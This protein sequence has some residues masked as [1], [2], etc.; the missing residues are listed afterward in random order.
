[1]KIRRSAAIAGL[2]G[3]GLA[4]GIVLVG[5]GAAYAAA[6]SY[7][8]D[9]QSFGTLSFFDSSGNPVTSG[10]ITN[11]PLAA[12]VV[13]SNPG[14]TGDTS[15]LLNL[16]QPNPNS[17][18]SGWNQDNLTGSSA[19]PLPAAG[20]PANIVALSQTHPVSKGTSS[21]FTVANFIS[22]FPNTGPTGTGCAYSVG[23][24][25]G[26]TNTAYQNLYEVRL[27]TAQGANQDPQYQVADI[28]VSGNTWTQVYG[29]WFT[30][31]TVLGSSANPG[32]TSTSLTL[33]ATETASD[34]THP[35]GSVQ[36][37]DGAANIGTPQAVNGS[38]VATLPTSFSTNGTHNLSAV[39]TP[40]TPAGATTFYQ[41]STGTL[42]ESIIPPPTATTTGLSVTQ[43]GTAG[44][45]VTLTATV[46][47][48]AAP[49]TV[50]FTDGASTIPGS[51]TQNP[52]G[53]YT[54]V[55]ATGLTAGSHTIVAHFAPTDPTAFQPSQSAPQTFVLAA[56]LQGACL[57]TGS[58]CT[59][60]QT[61]QTTVPVGTLVISTPYTAAA[62]LVLQDMALNSGATMLTTSAPF[63]NI[64]VTD[65]RSGDL[66]YTVTALSTGLSTAQTVP[67]GTF[68]TINGEN[69]GLTGLSGAG[70]GGYTGNTVLTNQAAAAGVVP[71]DTAGG[72][73]TGGASGATIISTDH[74]V[75]TLT[76]NGTLTINAPTATGPGLYTGTITFTVG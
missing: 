54:L 51:P 7:E 46:S 25:A 16:A 31:T 11:A 53:T 50:S 76:V 71:S 40:S 56:P 65:N 72:G 43:D 60:T 26:C 57:V 64:V 19:Y 47:P 66:P 12:Y 59:D 2:A 49:G 18:T 45:Q 62:P 68:N 1:V 74:G 48:S 3:F 75:G 4:A 17:A 33:T 73:L 42:A 69:V 63:Q 5:G 61:I 30:T 28:L 9:P 24:P 34:N 29:E 70:T 58:Q 38:G 67:A 36:F 14:R 52:T 41:G 22:E 23:N 39:F 21:D 35:A 10:T 20:N 37:M 6:P 15:T 8:P 13:G 32:Y 27:I 44:D 55:L